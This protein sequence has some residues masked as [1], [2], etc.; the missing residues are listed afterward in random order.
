MVFFSTTL[1]CSGLALLGWLSFRLWRQSR[2]RQFAAFFW[3]ALFLKLAGGLSVGWLYKYY[4]PDGGDTW[5]FFEQTEVLRQLAWQDMGTYL[6]RL[7]SPEYTTFESGQERNYYAIHWFSLWHLL[8]G[9]YWLTAVYLSWL[10][11]LG[12]WTCAETLS[13]VLPRSAAKRIGLAFFLLPSVVF[14]TSGWLKE[15][16]VWSLLGWMIAAALR[17]FYLQKLPPWW[18]WGILLIGGL[19]LWKI[20]YYYLAALLPAVFSYAVAKVWQRRIASSIFRTLGVQLLAYFLLLGLA[21][22]LHWNL[23]PEHL[24]A[25][26]FNSHHLIAQN[27][28]PESLLLSL[29][30]VPSFLA[31][32]WASPSALVSSL[33]RPFFWEASGLLEWLTALETFFVLVAGVYSLWQY[34]NNP[35]ALAAY[36]PELLG[37]LLYLLVLAV[38]LPLA[39]PNAGALV[40]FRMSFWP[41]WVLLCTAFLD[42][43]KDSGGLSK[44]SS[45]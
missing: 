1:T 3:P 14:W 40:R 39:A 2:S 38:L 22:R 10:S 20:K 37:L 30:E 21:T 25:A 45:H 35:K 6:S 24:V 9:S 12:L 4:L 31:L 7:F 15:S 32:L 41:F 17:Y 36:A 27:T 18:Q 33:A 11:F 8:G 28:S 34:R 23:H 42:S 29:P 16:I 19:L 5:F 26:I 43:P 44:Q 13:R